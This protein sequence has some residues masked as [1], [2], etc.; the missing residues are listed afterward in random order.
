VGNPNWPVTSCRY[1][2]MP[3][4]VPTGQ[5]PANIPLNSKSC[6]CS[7]N[8]FK[9]LASEPVILRTRGGYI[10]YFATARGET[11]GI[12][13]SCVQIRLDPPA[14]LTSVTSLKES[15]EAA[16][17]KSGQTRDRSTRSNCSKKEYD[18]PAEECLDSGAWD[19]FLAHR[20][21]FGQLSQQELRGAVA[22]KWKA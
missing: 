8:R 1:A 14:S 13:G 21:N 9:A 10:N 2:H 12:F 17:Q 11:E 7:S 4:V 5:Y 22:V 3:T 16:L 18:A 6:N 19:S 20:H 15:R